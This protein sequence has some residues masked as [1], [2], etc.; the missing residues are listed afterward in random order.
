MNFPLLSVKNNS[1]EALI[2]SL[3]SGKYSSITIDFGTYQLGLITKNSNLLE[4][5]GVKVL[6]LLLPTTTLL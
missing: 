2:F 5:S 4:N 3:I 6:G 1:L